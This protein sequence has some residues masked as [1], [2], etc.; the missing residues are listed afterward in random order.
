[1]LEAGLVRLGVE[2][3]ELHGPSAKLAGDQL[4]AAFEVG[5]VDDS[6]AHTDR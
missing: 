4:S 6:M 2:L 3:V 5:R 1:V